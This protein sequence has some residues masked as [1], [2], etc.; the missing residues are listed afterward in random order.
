VR[1]TTR[2][3]THAERVPPPKLGWA[4]PDYAVVQSSM[5][6]CQANLLRVLRGQG[7]AETDAADNLRTM[8]LVFAGYDS[9]ER[10]Q[11]VRAGV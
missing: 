8:R 1:V 7:A 5:V 11:V 2:T 6:A 3:G 4:D 10:G 9:A